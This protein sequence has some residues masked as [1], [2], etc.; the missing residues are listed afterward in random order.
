LAPPSTPPLPP[1]LPAV[2]APVRPLFLA[3]ATRVPPLL[4]TRR[5]STISTSLP[6]SMRTCLLLRPPVVAAPVHPVAPPAAAPLSLADRTLTLPV[7]PPAAAPVALADRAPPAFGRFALAAAEA[8]WPAPGVSS[9]IAANV[10]D[11]QVNMPPR[12]GRRNNEHEHPQI[13]LIRRSWVCRH[14]LGS[15][16]VLWDVVVVVVDGVAVYVGSLRFTRR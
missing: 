16:P 2:A 15:R 1:L 4:L 14:W 5:L 3:A 6:L 11:V 9:I 13:R 8:R 12:H 10:V 7:A